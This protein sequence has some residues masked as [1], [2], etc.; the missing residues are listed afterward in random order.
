MTM[1]KYYIFIMEN[2]HL[3]PNWVS[4]TEL[5]APIVAISPFRQPKTLKCHIDVTQHKNIVDRKMKSERVVFSP[6]W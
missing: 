5:L 4:E 2:S 1:K 3:K 6:Q